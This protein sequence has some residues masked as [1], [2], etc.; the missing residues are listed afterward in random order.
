MNEASK[1][2]VKEV[3]TS[4]PARVGEPEKYDAQYERNG[5]MES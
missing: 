1:P 4:I 3:H 5:V 2:L